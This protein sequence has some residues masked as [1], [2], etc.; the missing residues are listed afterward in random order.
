MRGLLPKRLAESD[1]AGSTGVKAALD[2]IAVHPDARGLNAGRL[3]IDAFEKAA[4]SQAATYLSLGVES[5]NSHAR[6]LYERC[7]WVLTQ[8]NIQKNS[9]NYRKEI[10]KH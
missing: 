7:G 3:L 6:R 9:A 8:D 10:R 4:A 2:S 1:Q 5:N